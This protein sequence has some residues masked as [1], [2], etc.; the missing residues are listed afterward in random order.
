[1]LKIAGAICAMV[2]CLSGPALAGA[3]EDGEAVYERGDIAGAIRLWRPLAEQGN[4]EAQ[5]RL[6]EFYF[7]G[8]GV[9][10]DR[11]EGLMWYRKAS[12]LGNARAQSQLAY[13]YW[14]GTGLQKDP[15]MAVNWWRK[16]ADQN[17]SGAMLNLGKALKTGVGVPQDDV[18]AAR[19]F[20]KASKAGTVEAQLEIGQALANGRGIPLDYVH[21]YMWMDIGARMLTKTDSR[22]SLDSRS[23]IAKKMTQ[24]EIKLAKAMAEVCIESSYRKCD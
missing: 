11:T 17:D 16:A 7:T 2:M 21:A 20:M 5:V 14:S 22:Q 10:M 6:A 8:F 3:F 18:E 24:A 23:Q 19:W 9:A 12:E 13:I 15:A 1:M 4:A